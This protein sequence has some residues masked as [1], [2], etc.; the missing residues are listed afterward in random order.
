METEK[1]MRVMGGEKKVGSRPRNGLE[2]ISAIRA[3][4]NFSTIQ[5]LADHTGIAPSRIFAAVN[6]SPRT[7]ERRR[8]Q[9]KLTSDESQKIARFARIVALGDD[10][11]EDSKVASQWLER[12][13]RALGGFKPME[14]LD[15]DEGAREVESVLLRLEYGVYS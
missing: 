7:M 14:L 5:Q 4:L 8:K 10:V 13:N 1:I 15:T 2:F 3:G 11:F 9:K 12:P 6:L